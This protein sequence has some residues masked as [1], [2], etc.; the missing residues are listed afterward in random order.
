MGPCILYV[1]LDLAS[2][3]LSLLGASGMSK[4]SLRSIASVYQPFNQNLS[5]SFESA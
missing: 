3:A 5:A 4:K 2:G 1:I